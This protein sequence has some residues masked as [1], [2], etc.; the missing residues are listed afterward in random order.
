MLINPNNPTGSYFTKKQLHV[1]LTEFSFCENII[2][3]ES[4]IHFAYE[5]DSLDMVSFYD[6]V[7]DNPNLIIVKSMSKDFGVAGV[8]IGYA[9]MREETVAKFLSTGYLWNSNGIAEYFVNLYQ[10]NSFRRTYEAER[11]RYIKDTQSF[12][13]DLT[14]IQGIVCY[15]SQANFS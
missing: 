11:K 4:F 3:D 2:L 14:D 10:E 7:D 9:V 12:Y 5:S 1:M 6:L 8:R 13:R 15:P